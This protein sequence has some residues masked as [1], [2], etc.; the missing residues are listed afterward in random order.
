MPGWEEG[1][2]KGEQAENEGGEKM[3]ADQGKTKEDKIICPMQNIIDTFGNEDFDNGN[4]WVAEKTARGCGAEAGAV[5][6]VD[7]DDTVNFNYDTCKILIFW[8]YEGVAVCS[9][10]IKSSGL[11][12]RGSCSKTKPTVTEDA[13]VTFEQGGINHGI[14]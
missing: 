6:N 8:S 11:R 1:W 12:A 5:V 4:P 10:Y 2:R 7:T 9:L 13:P 14:Y 3:K